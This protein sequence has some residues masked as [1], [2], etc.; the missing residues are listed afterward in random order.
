MKGHVE[1]SP[2]QILVF[3]RAFH[4]ILSKRY[5]GHWFPGEI[6]KKREREREEDRL[7]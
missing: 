7:F 1:L 2:E 5:V 3:K 6:M 4:D